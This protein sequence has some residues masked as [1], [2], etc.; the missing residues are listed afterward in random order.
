MSWARAHWLVGSLAIV[1][2]LS[3]GAYMRYVAVVPQL[4]DAPRMVFRSRF[5]F[6]LLAAVANFGLSGVQPARPIQRVAS[7][8]I[9]AAP[10][11]L[12]VSFFIDAGRGV[13]SSP[14]TVWTMRSLFLASLLLAFANRPWRKSV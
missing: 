5:L 13:Q 2:F 12:I 14:W 10:F 9:L 6:L 4:D 3:A 8:L 1:L 7:A 11:P